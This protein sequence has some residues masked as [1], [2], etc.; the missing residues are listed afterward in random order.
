MKEYIEDDQSSARS[1][2]RKFSATKRRGLWDKIVANGK[3]EFFHGPVIIKHS[4]H[5]A[6]SSAHTSC[7][8][9]TCIPFAFRYSW[10]LN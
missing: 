3:D 8:M 5:T 4:A 1:I 7:I 2:Y 10:R 6:S 9:N